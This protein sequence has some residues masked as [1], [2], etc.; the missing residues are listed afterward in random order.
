MLV[1][2]MIE[3]EEIYLDIRRP[4]MNAGQCVSSCNPTPREKTAQEEMIPHLRPTM[5]AIGNARRAPKN[6]PAERI[7][8]CQCLFDNGEFE[9]NGYYVQPNFYHL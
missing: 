7:E 1:S 4:T 8:T 2:K 5:S 3:V 9:N 6:V